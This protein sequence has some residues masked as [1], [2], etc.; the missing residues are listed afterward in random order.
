MHCYKGNPSNLPWI[1]MVWVPFNDPSDTEDVYNFNWSP[2]LDLSPR[3]LTPP[4]AFAVAHH[5]GLLAHVPVRWSIRNQVVLRLQGRP[6]GVMQEAS[7][8]STRPKQEGYERIYCELEPSMY[9]C[10]YFHL[11]TYIIHTYTYIQRS[12]W[13]FISISNSLIDKERARMSH[14]IG[15]K[16]F[17]WVS[18]SFPSNA[19]RR[20]WNIHCWK[21][22]WLHDMVSIFKF[23]DIDIGLSTRTELPRTCI[24]ESKQNEESVNHWRQ[25]LDFKDATEFTMSL[26][27]VNL[28]TCNGR[29][30]NEFS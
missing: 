10:I 6:Q 7:W 30:S 8:S 2:K 25:R 20:F 3:T 17:G 29:S 14:G 18:Y 24:S 1:C 13:V 22:W 16:E 27:T 12:K 23:C 26:C 19:N 9:I 11:H 21:T 15:E 28:L 4:S 5:H